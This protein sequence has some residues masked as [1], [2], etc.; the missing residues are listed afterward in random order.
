[1]N[2]IGRP[3]QCW[4]VVNFIESQILM[5]ILFLRRDATHVPWIILRQGWKR[6]LTTFFSAI[7]VCSRSRTLRAIAVPSIFM[8]GMAAGKLE[9]A[10]RPAAGE[11]RYGRKRALLLLLL[12]PSFKV[13]LEVDGIVPDV[14]RRG[15]A[16]PMAGAE[17]T[18]RMS[19]G[20][21]LLTS[22]DSHVAVAAELRG[23]VAPG[24]VRSW[25]FPG[26]RIERCL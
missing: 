6:G 17:E 7:S 14:G 3:L 11:E 12:V 8:A 4:L 16:E 26:R 18:R 19:D 24:P 2:R 10:L 9:K 21:L 22:P 23:A 25:L 15:A 1:M 13:G 20:L 5:A